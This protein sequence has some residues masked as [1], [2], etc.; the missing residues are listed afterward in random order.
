MNSIDFQKGSGLILND[1]LIPGTNTAN[2]EDLARRLSGKNVSVTITNELPLNAN[3]LDIGP[4]FAGFNVSYDTAC[5]YLQNAQFKS[6]VYSWKL[7]VPLTVACGRVVTQGSISDYLTKNGVV[8]IVSRSHAEP[9]SFTFCY[10][11]GD[12]DAEY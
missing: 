5:A 1:I 4:K 8:V 11:Y 10:A 12:E 6:R 3:L 9:L 7:L 2:W